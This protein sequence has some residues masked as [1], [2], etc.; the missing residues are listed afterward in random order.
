VVSNIHDPSKKSLSTI[1]LFYPLIISNYCIPW[2]KS[3]HGGLHKDWNGSI[4]QFPQDLIFLQE[5]DVTGRLAC[6]NLTTHPAP[7]KHPA[8]GRGTIKIGIIMDNII[9]ENKWIIMDN[10][11]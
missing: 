8:P 10:N 11:G 7:G 3:S 4:P 1:P 9:M 5:L 2:Q 6:E